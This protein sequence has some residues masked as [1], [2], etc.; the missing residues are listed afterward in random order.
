MERLVV[1]AI[2]SVRTTQNPFTVLRSVINLAR[3]KMLQGRLQ[4]AAVTFEEV[5]RV[6]SG[7]GQREVLVGNPAYYFGMGDVLREWNDLDAAKRHL[8]QGMDLLSGM[9]T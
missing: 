3:L 7:P 5:A 1:E 8:E 9:P 2:T 6:A 4:Q